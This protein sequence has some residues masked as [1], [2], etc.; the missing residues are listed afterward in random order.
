MKN[1]PSG[2]SRKQGMRSILSE[3]L[4]RPA[5][6]SPPSRTEYSDGFP[7][8]TDEQSRR[9]LRNLTVESAEKA[10]A[11]MGDLVCGMAERL[12]FYE[13]DHPALQKVED[14]RQWL[15]KH[16]VWSRG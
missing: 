10:L 9:A 5:P 16:Q 7:Y 1:K 14:M 3:E 2:P 4:M 12:K 11:R 8:T 13:P 15:Y 6:I